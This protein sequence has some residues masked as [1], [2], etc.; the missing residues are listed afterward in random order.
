MVILKRLKEE[1]LW[2]GKWRSSDGHLLNIKKCL[3]Q[4]VKKKGSASA[5]I[6]TGDRGLKF[7]FGDNGRD[8]LQ[9]F[10]DKGFTAMGGPIKYS[11]RVITD[12]GDLSVLVAALN[13][14]KFMPSN[15]FI[16]WVNS[17]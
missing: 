9:Y 2:T 13:K 8:V 1:L 3:D 11:G 16:R 6:L 10:M 15:E 17:G 12:A 5:S 14:M 7:Y 4:G